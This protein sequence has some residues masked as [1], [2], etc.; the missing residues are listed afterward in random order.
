M[1]IAWYLTG[2][3]LIGLTAMYALKESAPVKRGLV[4][5]A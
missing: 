3:S 5:P 4:K 1:S 2:V